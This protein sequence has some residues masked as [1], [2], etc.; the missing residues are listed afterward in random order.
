MHIP[1]DP[2][3]HYDEAYYFSPGNLGFRSFKT[4]Y[5][6]IGVLVCWDQWYPEAAR[7]VAVS[8]ADIIFYPT[9]IGWPFK[10][11]PGINEAEHEAWQTIQRSHAIA[12]NVFVAAVNRVGVDHKL[13]FW[14]TTFVSDPY[15]R[16]IARASWSKEEDLLVP[17]DLSL[18]S[19]MRRDWPFLKARRIKVENR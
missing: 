15:G 4:R 13:R 8:G 10:S 7:A 11:R 19:A 17:C 12:N 5:G 2:E 14:G 3:N 9:A 1:D 16:V 18:T 6:R